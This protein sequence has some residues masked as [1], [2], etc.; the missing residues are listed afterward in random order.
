MF[1][2]FYFWFVVV[3]ACVGGVL[4]VDVTY[5]PPYGGGMA[6]WRMRLRFVWRFAD[7]CACVVDDIVV[8]DLLLMTKPGDGI[9]VW[10]A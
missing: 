5:L 2:H 4:L 6:V 3:V 1:L 10:F 9:V 7:V 8:V